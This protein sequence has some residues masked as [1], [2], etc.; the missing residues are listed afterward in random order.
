MAAGNITEQVAIIGKIA[1][2]GDIN[3]VAEARSEMVSAII[4]VDPFMSVNLVA[5][6]VGE[7]IAYLAGY[8][9]HELGNEALRLFNVSHPIFGQNIPDDLASAFATGEKLAHQ[10]NLK[11]Q[12]EAENAKKLRQAKEL[13]VILPDGEDEVDT[14]T[15]EQ[16]LNAVRAKRAA[17][18][19]VAAQREI[20]ELRV[21]NEKRRE[22]EELAALEAAAKAALKPKEETLTA[23]FEED[24]EEEE[25]VYECPECGDC[26][27]IPGNACTECDY[28]AGKA[29]KEQAEREAA[30]AAERA[31][32][33]AMPTTT[34]DSDF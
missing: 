14:D 9:P 1:A 34:Y 27:Y 19:D 31:A 23:G 18:G 17:R 7:Q 30:E 24:E 20:E 25:G 13:G 10:F 12:I 29:A 4:M 28:D 15:A 5:D 21:L 6:R 16:I 32:Y 2:E 3:G 11:K 22:E 33:A 26:D 8:L